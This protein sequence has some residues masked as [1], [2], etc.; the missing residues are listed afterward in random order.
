MK[1]SAPGVP[2]KTT[3]FLSGHKTDSVF[4]RYNI[5][6][7]GDNREAAKKIEEDAK[8]A[9]WGSIQSSFIVEPKT[10]TSVEVAE[11][12]KPS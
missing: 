4:A 3:R 12:R 8:A 9:V 5:V 10:Q 6:S 7:E 11:E 1:H 2:L